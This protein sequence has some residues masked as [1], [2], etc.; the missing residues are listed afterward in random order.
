M[1]GRYSLHSNP[2]VIALQFGLQ[3]VP[4]FKRSYNIAPDAQVLVVR[5]NGAA[6]AR[7]RFKGKTHNARL[8]SLA[9]KSLF[10][11]ARRCLLPANGFYEWQR[12]S[13]GSQPYFVRLEE[14]LFGMAAIC[15]E[16]TCAV[17]TTDAGASMAHIHD[18]MPLIVPRD[19]Y[20][21]WLSGKDVAFLKDVRAI[22]VSPAVNNAA[23]DSPDLIRSVEP[24]SRD[25]FD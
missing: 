4:N 14:E 15:D 24:A 21:A 22:P 11:N 1:C 16:Q 8:D 9:S 7:W 20:G 23:N 19:G 25:L 12:R 3:G 5:S 18:R 13:T 6:M 17:V 2:D 10:R